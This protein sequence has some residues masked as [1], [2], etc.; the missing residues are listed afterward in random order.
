MPN[1]RGAIFVS[2]DPSG[3]FFYAAKSTKGGVND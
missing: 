2:D 1:P 3:L